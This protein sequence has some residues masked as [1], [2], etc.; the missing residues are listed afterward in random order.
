M[1]PKLREL[2]LKRLTENSETHDMRR[3]EFNQAIFDR[4]DG[5]AVYAGTDLWM[6]MDAFDNAAKDLKMGMK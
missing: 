3:K 2:F 5:C 4:N 1:I 6:V